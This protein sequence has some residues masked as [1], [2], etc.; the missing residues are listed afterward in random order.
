MT[1]ITPVVVDNTNMQLW[2]M[3]GYVYSAQHF[4]YAVQVVHPSTFDPEWKDVVHLMQRNAQRAHLGKDL[5]LEVLRRM[6]RRFEPFESL[7]DI[8]Q[9]KAKTERGVQDLRSELR[10]DPTDGCAYGLE[11]FV[12]EYGGTVEDPPAEWFSAH[13]APVPPSVR[14]P[15]EASRSSSS[16]RSRSRTRSRSRSRSRSRRLLRSQLV[17]QR[18]WQAASWPEVKRQLVEEYELDVE[19]DEER[20]GKYW[21]RCLGL[22]TIKH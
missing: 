18:L 2:E 14:A 19:E 5:P 15:S 4:G 16:R 12:E 1:G 21:V 11:D 9:A 3:Q 22:V 7:Q 10:V 8:L 17:L 13:P 20:I 6:L